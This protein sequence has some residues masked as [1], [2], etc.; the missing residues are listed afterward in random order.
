M[1]GPPAARRRPDPVGPLGSLAPLGPPAPSAPK[2]STAPRA[3]TRSASR[4]PSNPS[5]QPRAPSPAL[6]P[7]PHLLAGGGQRYRRLAEWIDARIADGDL[8]PGTRLPPERDLAAALG[9]SRT[10]TVAAYRELAARGLVRAHVGRGTFVAAPREPGT[11]PFAWRGKVSATAL[12]LTDA[13]IRDLLRVGA[14]PR[15]I[16][17]AAGAPALDLFPLAAFE[18]ALAAAMRHGGGRVWGHGPTEGLPRLREVLAARY[19]VERAKVLIVSGAQQG[20]D[21]VARCLIDPDDAVIMERPGYLGAIQ[22]FRAA[23]AR[24]MGW[25]VVRGDIDELEDLLLRYRPKLLYTNPT[26]Q[27]P[28]GDTM[29]LATRRD[30]LALARRYRLPVVED[31]TYRE[32]P[33]PGI[34]PPPSLAELDG[35]E[36]VIGVGTFSKIL[37]PGLRLGWVTAAPAVIDQLTLVKQ[38]ADPHTQNLVQEAV[39]RFIEADGFDRHLQ[40]L[41]VEHARRCRA[42]RDTLGA[43]AHRERPRSGP[44]QS[45]QQRTARAQAPRTQAARAGTTRRVSAPVPATTRVR[46]SHP[47]GGLYLWGRLAPGLDARV[48][49]QRAMEHGVAF[50]AGD[51]F[52]PDGGG[53]ST[54]R[55]CFSSVTPEVARRGIARLMDCLRDMPIAQDGSMPIV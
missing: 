53:A 33:F 52:Y 11:A 6:L 39:A 18:R 20:I 38:R 14:D 19:E 31:D 1:I 21:L 36:V 25:D 43:P 8:A 34:T 40:V 17:F 41:R 48:L 27:N 15:V 10:T 50:V 32:L 23:G 42:M 37:A 22:A 4:A 5:P 55:V 12:R 16:S 46:W 26:F 44:A 9:I 13:T 35:H 45:Q 51:A 29:P 49:L 24:I 54:L 7:P 28:I 2:T 3:R 47:T 30:L